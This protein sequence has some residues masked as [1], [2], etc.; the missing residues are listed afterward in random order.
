MR[1]YRHQHQEKTEAHPSNSTRARI[2][3]AQ[4]VIHWLQQTG[5]CPEHDNTITATFIVDL[6]GAL[7]IADR[8]SEHLACPNG[9]DVLSAGEITFDLDSMPVR[10]ASVT[11][12]SLGY[13]PEAELWP[14]SPR[15]WRQ[16]EFPRP[17]SSRLNSYSVSAK[18]AARRMSF[19]I[20]G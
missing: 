7:W 4:D 16:S 12:Q 1:A 6:D 3:A 17:A 18:H 13:C 11:N 8:R 14:A 9:R 15:L 19:A 20:T 10:V 5:Q 2:A